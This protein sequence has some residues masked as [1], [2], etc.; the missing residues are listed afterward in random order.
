MDLIFRNLFLCRHHF[1]RIEMPVIDTIFNYTD[2]Y[3]IGL[4]GTPNQTDSDVT[5][6]RSDDHGKIKKRIER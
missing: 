4:R 1:L 5:F 3:S 2:L 6:S